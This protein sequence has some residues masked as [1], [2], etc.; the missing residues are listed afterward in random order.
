MYIKQEFLSLL[1]SISTSFAI[2]QYVKLDILSVIII[3]LSIY[4]IIRNTITWLKR[5]DYWYYNGGYSGESCGK[6]GRY[7]KR[8]PKDMIL[9]CKR[10]GWKKGRPILRYLTDSVIVNQLYR[11]FRHP[12]DIISISIKSV[13]K[14]IRSFITFILSIVLSNLIFYL[15]IIILGVFLF[16]GYSLLGFN[17]PSIVPSDSDGDNINDAVENNSLSLNTYSKDIEVKLVY[18]QDVSKLDSQEKRELINIWDDMDV[19]NPSNNRGINL[20]ITNETTA[21]RSIQLSDDLSSTERNNKLTKLYQEYTNEDSCGTTHIVVLGHIN[22]EGDLSGWGSSPGY[23]VFVDGTETRYQ[24]G[25]SIRVQTITH[26]LLHNIVGTIEG[27]HIDGDSKHTESGWLSQRTGDQF[28]SSSVSSQL[29]KNGFSDA[30]YYQ[31]VVC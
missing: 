14:Y 15:I 11:S 20:R 4:F 5:I 29:S 30:D 23:S 16:G 19:Q 26:E 18:S 28:L 10:C 8:Q 13:F 27:S 7:V 21:S 3:N 9:E 17:T 1:I 12:T 22:S 24:D 2:Y 6:C 25:N 31:N